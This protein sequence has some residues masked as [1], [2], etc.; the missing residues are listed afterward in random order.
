MNDQAE[1]LRRLLRNDQ[2]KDAKVIAIV[3][4]KGGV[5][6][7]N[8]CLNVAISLSKLGKKVAIF[9]LDI[10]MANLNILMGLTANYHLMDLLDNQLSIWDI[11]EE[12][13]AGLSYIAGGSGFSSFVE[14]TDERLQK[15]FSQLELIGE[16]FD[17]IFL[18][19]GA[20]A[21]KESVELVMAVHEVF[22]V[23]T[24]EPTAM[25]DAYSM[26][27]FIHLKDDLKPMYLIVNRVDSE[28]E[29][30]RTIESFKKVALQF[31]QK[32]ISALGYIPND[33]AVSKAVKAQTP[34]VLF[35]SFSKGSQAVARIAALYIGQKQVTPT[36][37]GQFLSKMRKMVSLKK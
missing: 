27:K 2:R 6:K 16:H 11:M 36:K 35:D 33:P 20:G 25:T 22:V 32:D 1:N 14:L 24:P 21:T 17:Y 30:L 18:D 13:P 7:S 28:K 34:F 15:F 8:V 12:G 29:G 26:I 23:T 37:Y 3:S 4:G 19:M 5:G 9:D 10:G 31:L